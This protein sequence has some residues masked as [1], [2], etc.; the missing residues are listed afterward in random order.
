MVNMIKAI[1]AKVQSCV[2][3]SYNNTISI[4]DFFEVTIGL[5]AIIFIVFINDMSS[6]I[7]YNCL[8]QDDLDL[9]SRYLILFADDIILFTTDPASLQAHID[10]IYT[11]SLKW[12]LKSNVCVF[13]KRK[14][15]H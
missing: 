9:L 1:Y 13:E 14:Q 7:D 15:F 12:S 11:Y 2:K 10:N 3:L 6:T 8:T 4:S 5:A